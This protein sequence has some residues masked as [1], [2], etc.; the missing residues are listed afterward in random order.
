MLKC[1]EGIENKKIGMLIKS[2]NKKVFFRLNEGPSVF[3]TEDE[4]RIVLKD[5][6]RPGWEIR[7]VKEKKA[8]EDD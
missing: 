2:T 8:R 1:V 5:F 7:K 6:E 4:E 3:L